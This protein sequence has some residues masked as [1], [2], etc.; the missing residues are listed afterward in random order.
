MKPIFVKRAQP[1][2]SILSVV[3]ILLSVLLA[4]ILG[5]GLIAVAGKD[6]VVAYQTLFSSVLGRQS[7]AIEML[8]KGTP[9]L[10]AGLGMVVAFK[11]RVWNVGG[12]G[13][14]YMGALAGTWVGIHVS[15]LPQALHLPAAL[16]AGALAGSLW[17]LVPALLKVYLKVSEVITTLMLNYI[18]ILFVS[19]LVHGP[20]EEVGG[21]MPQTPRIAET[22][23]LPLIFPPTRLHA[24]VILAVAAALLVYLLLHKT[25][26]GYNI[27]AVGANPNASECGGVKTGPTILVVMLI[28]GALAGL[29]GANEILGFHYRLMDG[30]SPGYGF[31][32]MVVALLGRLNPIGVIA[33]GYLFSGLYVGSAQ[34]QRVM[35][36]PIALS[37]VIQGLVV[38]CVLGTEILLDYDFVPI[39]R[40]GRWIRGRLA[41]AEPVPSLPEGS[42]E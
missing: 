10:L 13:Q 41:G 20:M 9:L 8:I 7:G 32:A 24:G 35:Q 29:A 39:N 26:L 37:Q 31:T 1:H 28:S 18:A 33:S 2:G 27:R 38:L 5:A 34:M 25:T 30:I 17:A 15:G 22:A 16:L 19:W 12:E 40:L 4:F 21:F 3:L 36:V 6:P 11:A 23:V 14:I 42:R